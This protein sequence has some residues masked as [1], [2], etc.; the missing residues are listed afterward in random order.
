MFL[1][2]VCEWVLCQLV[3]KHVSSFFICA[4]YE[5]RGF[6]NLTLC[7]HLHTNGLLARLR[8]YTV[9]T[10]QRETHITHVT[11]ACLCTMQHV[12]CSQHVKWHMR[13]LTPCGLDS[14]IIRLMLMMTTTTP[15]WCP[16]CC[17]SE[18]QGQKSLCSK[19]LT[20]LF[21]PALIVTCNADVPGASPCMSL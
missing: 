3:Q 1:T 5:R 11:K 20:L 10:T 14:D 18:R 8:L 13:E 7:V 15:C 21:P 6:D 19:D 4:C 12:L 2:Q 16:T 9:V 17:K